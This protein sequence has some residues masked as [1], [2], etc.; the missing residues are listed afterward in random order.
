MFWPFPMRPRIRPFFTPVSRH[1]WLFSGY[2]LAF[3]GIISRK[4]D[5]DSKL[6]DRP[7][8]GRPSLTQS[9]SIQVHG[10]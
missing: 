8:C 4:F 10:W 9:S 7:A 3:N 2:F 5:R 6:R 1:L